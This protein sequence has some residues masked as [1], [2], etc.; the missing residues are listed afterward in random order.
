MNDHQ[1]PDSELRG[2]GAENPVDPGATALAEALRSSFVIVK[3]VMV[4]LLVVFLGSGFFKVGPDERAII[5]RLGKPVGAG[6]AA[7]L[8]PGLHW[9]WPYPIDEYR[10]VSIS[11]IQ[12]VTSSVG[13]YATTPEQELAGTEPMAGPTLNPAVDGYV[14]TADGNI[15]HARATLTYRIADPITFVFNFVNASN[16]VQNALDNALHFA[17]TQYPV[18]NIL[19]RDKIGFSETVRRR[20]TELATRQN[21]GIVVEQCTVEG[22]PPRQLRDAFANVLKAEIA[23]SKA[24][25]EARSHENQVTNK[26]GADAQSRLNLA[27]SERVRLV[28]EVKSRADVFLALLPKYNEN[29]GLFVQQ[30]L[31]ESLGRVMTNVQD[32]I[33]LTEGDNG[34][35]KELRLLLNR[36]LPKAK[37]EEPK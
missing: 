13:W 22:I 26:A 29:P 21:L 36:E 12:R 32:K 31:T 23:R 28:A 24:L 20:T 6:E 15:A 30:R 1:H 8:G 14:L 19:T 27:E 16:A 18:D 34:R 9:S 3:A 5:L 17:A 4:V 10:K 7:L 25:N 11:G 35:T 37:T 2:P 33:F